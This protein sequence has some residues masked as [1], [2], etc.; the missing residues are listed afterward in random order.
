MSCGMFFGV[1]AVS[2]APIALA[3]EEILGAPIDACAVGDIARR[4]V[5]ALVLR[6]AAPAF[7][8]RYGER[9]RSGFAFFPTTSSFSNI[10]FLAR[11]SLS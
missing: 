3:G 10:V 6:E 5:R 7:C 11:I 8:R 9:E 2:F 4:A 1:V